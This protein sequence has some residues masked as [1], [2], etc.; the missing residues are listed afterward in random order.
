MIFILPFPKS[1]IKKS[2]PLLKRVKKLEQRIK[3]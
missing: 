3:T 1:P 2:L